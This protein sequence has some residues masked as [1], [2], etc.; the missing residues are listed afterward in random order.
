MFAFCGQREKKKKKIIERQ[1]E[2]ERD[3]DIHFSYLGF[4]ISAHKKFFFPFFFVSFGKEIYKK[5]GEDTHQRYTSY[6]L[7]DA[8][9]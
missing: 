8:H 9:T 2:R 7:F 6:R 1:R 4:C 3:K 5:R